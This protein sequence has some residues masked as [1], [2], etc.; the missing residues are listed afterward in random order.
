M[1]IYVYHE[2]FEYYFQK[3]V[4]LLGI[5]ITKE[6]HIISL[7]IKSHTHIYKKIRQFWNFWYNFTNEWHNC[8]LLLNKFRIFTFDLFCCWHW[9]WHLICP[10]FLFRSLFF[11]LIWYKLPEGFDIYISFHPTILIIYN[12]LPALHSFPLSI[13]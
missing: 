8:L 1:I 5:L 2:M 9:H 11:K 7:I 10:F 13:L 6:M 12:F 4:I 3:R